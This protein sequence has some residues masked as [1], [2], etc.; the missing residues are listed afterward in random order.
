M[1]PEDH[2]PNVAP[3]YLSCSD[4]EGASGRS[5]QD[6]SPHSLQTLSFQQLM[7][8]DAL[9]HTHTH[10]HAHTHTCTPPLMHTRTDT[11]RHTHTEV[12]GGLFALSSLSVVQL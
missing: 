12:R 11:H 6:M 2:D 5:P 10:M 3:G 7:P 4:L 8:T 9:V 1:R